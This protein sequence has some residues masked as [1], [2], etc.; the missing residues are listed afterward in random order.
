MPGRKGRFPFFATIPMSNERKVIRGLFLILILATVCASFLS[1]MSMITETALGAVLRYAW[2]A[3]LGVLLV[4]HPRGLFDKGIRFFYVYSALFLLLC[5]LYDAV[6]VKTY[7]G[8]DARNVIIALLV[9][10]SSYCY[11][12]SYG[13]RKALDVIC[14]ASLV[15]GLIL[16][17]DAYQ[18]AF[19]DYD[20]TLEQAYVYASKNSM[21]LIL[22]C[23]ALVSFL[24]FQSKNPLKMIPLLAA[25]F[26]MI[27]IIFLMKSRAVLVSL[28]F[29][30]LYFILQSR[31]KPV[32]W[33]SVLLTIV[34]TC[35]LLFNEEFYNVVVNGIVLNAHD[36]NDITAVT[37]ERDILL[38]E[39]IGMIPDAFFWGYGEFYLDCMPLAM[40]IQYGII[41]VSIILLYLFQIGREVVSF[42]R[43]KQLHLITFLLFGTL[44]INALFEAQAPF[45]PGMKCFIFWMFLGFSMAESRKES[46]ER[47]YLTYAYP[48]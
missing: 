22:L 18:L 1:Q 38:K 34:F 30:I 29:L 43:S 19:I 35:L 48:R 21:A 16:S 40:L 6:S 31:S 7:W 28:A 39:A 45:G 33:F 47:K 46:L 44:M 27:Y 36:I 12:R 4:F 37:S 13:S 8:A 11:W 14:A 3:F 41:G 9:F 42:D 26:Y 17:I 2:V 32:K 23:I 20:P 24:R 10:V 15:C 5:L 25:V